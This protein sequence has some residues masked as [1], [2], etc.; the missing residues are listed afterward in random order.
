[1][2]YAIRYHPQ[3]T[4]DLRRL[5]KGVRDKV[6]KKIAQLA[7]APESG[8]LLGN[9]AGLDLSGYR[10]L[11]ADNRRIRVVYRIEKETICVL[12]LAVGK[13][14][15]LEIYRLARERLDNGI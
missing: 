1:M 3:V 13:R 6:F 10:K 7:H 8:N 2:L 12:I 4:D 15:N 11:Y 5:D 9:K 14:E